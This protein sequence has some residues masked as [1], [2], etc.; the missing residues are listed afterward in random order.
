VPDEPTAAI[1]DLTHARTGGEPVLVSQKVKQGVCVHV[2][3]LL[4]PGVA[5]AGFFTG[6]AEFCPHLPTLFRYRFDPVECTLTL[7]ADTMSWV[8][9]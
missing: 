8:Y 2:V 4:Y 1:L 5:S 3:Q 9:R 7:T 6:P